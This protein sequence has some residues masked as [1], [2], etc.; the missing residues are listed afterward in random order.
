MAQITF[1]KNKPQIANDSYS[2]LLQ[3][4][5]DHIFQTLGGVVSNDK[6]SIFIPQVIE[7][8]KVLL[9]LKFYRQDIYFN[10]YYRTS[11]FSID[12]YDANDKN[13]P[14]KKFDD[15]KIFDDDYFSKLVYPDKIRP[16]ISRDVFPF[17]T[18]KTKKR[19][20]VWYPRESW[21]NPAHEYYL[22]FD[23]LIV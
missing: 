13:V 5:F 23:D 6:K 7:N 9:V 8:K 2:E 22:V 21:F 10:P 3:P 17:T 4:V 1:D 16:V 15:S 20:V 11:R 19:Y 14:F 18:Y 12:A